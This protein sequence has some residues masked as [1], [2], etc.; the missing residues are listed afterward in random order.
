[1]AERELSRIEKDAAA[2]F[3]LQASLIIHRYG[4]LEAGQ[5]IVLVVTA[6]AHRANAFAAAELLM[7]YLKTCAPFWKREHTD[8]G[9]RWV[10]ADDKDDAAAARWRR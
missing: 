4:K 3:N 2:R 1:M 10:E 6:A 9:V 7:D 5:R 8:S